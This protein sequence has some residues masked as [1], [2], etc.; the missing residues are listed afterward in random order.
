MATVAKTDQLYNQNH[1]VTTWTA[2]TTTNADGAPVGYASNGMGGVTAQ[3]T[4]TIG[5]GFSLSIQGSNDGTTW[6]TL[7]DQANTAVTF[8]ALGLKTIRDMPLLIRPFVS[9]GDGTTNVNVILAFQKSAFSI[10]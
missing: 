4:G 1:H 2:L 8:A 3:V 9:A 7:N 10:G 5:A 6:Y